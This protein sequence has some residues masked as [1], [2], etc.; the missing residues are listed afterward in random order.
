VSEP[1]NGNTLIQPDGKDGAVA[2]PSLKAQMMIVSPAAW[3]GSVIVSPALVA[4]L[5]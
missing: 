2:T 5:I 1:V 3:V 4:A